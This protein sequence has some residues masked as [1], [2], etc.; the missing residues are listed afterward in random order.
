MA[1]T[2]LN[3][4]YK[5]LARDYRSPWLQRPHGCKDSGHEWAFFWQLFPVILAVIT[6]YANVL[7][8]NKDRENRR[9][10]RLYIVC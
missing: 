4:N 3:Y 2:N 8:R 6:P 5:L 7:Y 10:H 1:I 9:R